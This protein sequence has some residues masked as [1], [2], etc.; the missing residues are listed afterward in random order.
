[1]VAGLKAVGGALFFVLIPEIA[2][3]PDAMTQT[4]EGTDG[5]IYYYQFLIHIY[6]LV[7]MY[8]KCFALEKASENNFLSSS[9][10]LLNS[11]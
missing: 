7:N 10:G 5:G 9:L 8:K 6:G 1:L 3:L 4:G 11:F 2:A